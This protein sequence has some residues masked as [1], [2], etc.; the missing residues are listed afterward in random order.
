MGQVRGPVT[1]GRFRRFLGC[2]SPRNWVDSSKDPNA[3]P[4]SQT[5]IT[6]PSTRQDGHPD[7][8][9]ET[10]HM[11]LVP[12]NEIDTPGGKK[13][14]MHTEVVRAFKKF[15]RI[16]ARRRVDDIPH[17]TISSF[18]SSGGRSQHQGTI[19]ARSRLARVSIASQ[20]GRFVRRSKRDA[21]KPDDF[22]GHRCGIARSKTNQD[23]LR[24]QLKCL[25]V[26]STSSMVCTDEQDLAENKV[27]FLADSV[28]EP[29]VSKFF[30]DNKRIRICDVCP[31]PTNEGKL[32]ESSSGTGIISCYGGDDVGPQD[33][34]GLLTWL[35]N[36]RIWLR[37]VSALEPVPWNL[38]MVCKERDGNC[39]VGFKTT[40]RR[41]G[42]TS[43]QGSAII[44]SLTFD[45]AA[46]DDLAG[47][48]PF[49][50]T[51]T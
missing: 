5:P 41:P 47:M 10:A 9:N 17:S 38:G 31:M 12:Q 36:G 44:S 4:K 51:R 40:G 34:E 19:Y 14:S 8:V 2:P 6:G 35:E 43:L 7:A 30:F 25:T 49:C 39:D 11:L 33:W 18:I 23:V 29:H 13:R 16:G 3:T 46:V 45:G 50:Y 15:T 20:P 37:S 32:L 28:G 22:A 42:K 48:L 21:E 27:V 26:V 1:G 24:G